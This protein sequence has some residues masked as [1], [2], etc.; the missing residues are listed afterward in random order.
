MKRYL[1]KIE[2][3]KESSLSRILSKFT[4]YDTGTITAFRNDYTSKENKA[5]NHSLKLKLRNLGYGI[6][7]VE[8]GYIENFNEPDEVHVGEYTFF[9]EDFKNKGRLKQDLIE[10]GEEFEQDSIMY[11]PKVDVLI[12]DGV[13]INPKTGNDYSRGLLVSSYLIGT[14]I[15][16]QWLKYHEEK[17]QPFLRIGKDDYEFYSKI[18][19]RPFHFRDV[20]SFLENKQQKPACNVAEK[21]TL[22][23]GS[24]EHWTYFLDRF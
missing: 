8:G 17:E 3:L 6:T 16:G 20:E 13:Q 7:E 4:K 21:R 15:D 9:V 14:S 2:N 1:E 12:Q 18:N 11:I 22:S 10:L 19:D 24:R 23:F 5:R